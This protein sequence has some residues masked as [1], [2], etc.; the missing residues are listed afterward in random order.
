MPLSV[1][2]RGPTA[3]T[4]DDEVLRFCQTL[5]LASPTLPIGAYSYSQ[6]LESAVAKGWVVDEATAQSWIEGLLTNGLARLDLPLVCRLRVALEGHDQERLR[7]WSEYLRASREAR[8]LVN[9][10]AALGLSLLKLLAEP[11]RTDPL[12]DRDL[13]VSLALGFAAAGLAWDISLRATLT[14]YAWSWFEN[15]V[16]AAVKLVP[17]G[18]TAGQRIIS[19]VLGALAAA[20]ATAETLPD[21]ALGALAPGFALACAHHETQYTRLFRS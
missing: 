11:Q 14:A 17:L 10:D 21:D 3:T 1:L 5:R 16:A 8:E 6:G 2:K 12:V 18:Q 13:P 7:F 19:G 15:Q 20:V 4:M 9:E